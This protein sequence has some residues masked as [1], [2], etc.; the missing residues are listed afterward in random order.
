MIVVDSSAL[1]A[2]LFGE[3]EKQAFETIIADSDRCIISAVNA[4]ET[5]T[6]LRLKRGPASVE[7]FWQMLADGE[8]EIIP[9]D[10]GQVRAA[11]AAF[12]RYSKGIN[13]RAQLNLSDCAAYALARIMN[14]PLLFKGDDFTH[15]DAKPC[16]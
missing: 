8:I 5:A 9:F 4:H 2:I 10:E 12:D 16:I 11:A 3:P 1:I 6:V 14:A 13:S 7:R 15:T